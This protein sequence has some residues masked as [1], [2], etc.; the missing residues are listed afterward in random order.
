VMELLGH[1]TGW[2]AHRLYYQRIWSGDLAGAPD[3]RRALIA[4]AVAEPLEREPGARALYSD[5]GYIVLGAAL[6]AA[7]CAPLQLLFADLVADPLGMRSARYVDLA[8]AWRPSHAV[9]TE[10]DDRR[11]LVA[12]EVHDENA[13]A[14]GGVHGHAGLFAEVGDVSRF[15]ALWCTLLRGE[16]AHGFRADVARD[17]ATLSAAPDTSLRLGWDTP[18]RTPGVSHAGDRWPREG[19]IGHLGF[20]GTSLWIDAA[21]SRWVALLTNRVHPSRDGERAGSIKQ[22]RRRV[23]DEVVEM[24]G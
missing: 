1:A 4:H 3:T 16:D 20:T 21:R 11:G 9:A 22:L 8:Q 23:M 24:L 2:P 5:V 6:E 15:G 12:G 18:S 13:H 7:G 10:I 17:F 14:G 19:A